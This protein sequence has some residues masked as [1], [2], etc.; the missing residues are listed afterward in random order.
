MRSRLWTRTVAVAL[1]IGL[2]MLTAAFTI[3]GIL[4]KSLSVVT[5]IVLA[6]TQLVRWPRT[7][8]GLVKPL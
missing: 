6:L 3:V 1:L 7:F 4:V 8:T 2:A 5:T